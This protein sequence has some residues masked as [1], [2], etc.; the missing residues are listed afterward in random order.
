MAKI[1]LTIEISEAIRELRLQNKIASK[2]VAGVLGRS[3]SYVSKIENGL[4][5]TISEE[6]FDQILKIL[7]PSSR[8]S[9]ERL[10]RLVEFQIKKYGVDSSEDKVWFYNLDTVYRLIP[11]PVGLIDEINGILAETTVDIEQLVVRINS[12]ED[13][14]ESERNDPSLPHNE[15]VES[16]DA[17]AKMIIR[18]KLRVEEVEGILDGTIEVCNF[19]TMQ[20]I[21]HYLFK[22]KLFPGKA[23]F[24]TSDLISVQKAWQEL[25]DKHKFYTLSR[26]EKLLSQ[27]HSKNQAKSILNDFDIEN[28][29][30]INEMLQFIKMASDMDVYTTNKSL[31]S[32]LSNLDWDYNFMLRIIGFDYASVGECSFSNKLQMLRDIREVI[33]KYKNMPEDQ[34]MLDT[35]GDLG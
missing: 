23:D 33:N 5:K 24:D 20:A 8:S 11:I 10:D 28:Q 21:V 18:M 3:A 17:D 15:W 22:F 35:Y 12:N 6:E 34:K 7:F 29:K 1:P 31:K 16:N 14:S 32:F 30:A 13:I 25:L 27:T 4:I 26:K 9:Q 19:V 2:E